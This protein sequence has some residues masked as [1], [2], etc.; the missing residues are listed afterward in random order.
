MLKIFMKRI[1]DIVNPLLGIRI[2]TVDGMNFNT[3][4]FQSFWLKSSAM[5][6]FQKV[7][8]DYA[9]I[10]LNNEI[11]GKTVRLLNRW[12]E[13]YKDLGQVVDEDGRFLQYEDGEG[14]VIPPSSL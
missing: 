7:K 5:K 1:S 9:V 10:D 8:G 2:W 13:K 12:D 4:R 11:T 3:G 6:Y 14:N